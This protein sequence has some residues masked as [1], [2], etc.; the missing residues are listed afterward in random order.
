M[1][2]SID[3]FFLARHALLTTQILAL[4]ATEEHLLTL[5]QTL[6]MLVCV[7]AIA[8]LILA[9]MVAV[10]ELSTTL[11]FTAECL[12]VIFRLKAT[13]D[14]GMMAARQFFASELGAAGGVT[15]LRL[16]TG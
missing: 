12:V 14:E 2:T 10:N 9:F 4:M 13:V 7:K 3:A 11:L 6:A 1:R 5:I 16:L 15:D 8:A